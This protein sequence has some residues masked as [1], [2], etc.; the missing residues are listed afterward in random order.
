MFEAALS[1]RATK[2]VHGAELFLLHG[3]QVGGRCVDYSDAVDGCGQSAATF[4]VIVHDSE[5]EPPAH[6]AAQD[7]GDFAPA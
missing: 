4:A 1:F 5:I 7:V 2:E 3:A 6:V